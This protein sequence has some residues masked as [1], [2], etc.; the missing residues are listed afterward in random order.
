[1]WQGARP[2]PPT[3]I[4]LDS[5][6]ETLGSER[7]FCTEGF[8]CLD[9]AIPNFLVRE[10]LGEEN[11]WRGLARR[12]AVVLDGLGKVAVGCLSVVTHNL[13][14]EEDTDGS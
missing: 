5:V 13:I 2:Y 4:V 9:R 11:I 10:V 12:T 1:M 14:L 3:L 8:G 6:S 7:A